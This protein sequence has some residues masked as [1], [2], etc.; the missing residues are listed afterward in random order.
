M[1]IITETHLENNG[2]VFVG[3]TYNTILPNPL[4][5]ILPDAFQ[6]EKQYS[7]RGEFAFICKEGMLFCVSAFFVGS[8]SK[9]NKIA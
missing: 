7:K 2:F 8:E 5:G 1:Y 4:T 6:E 3:G 9:Q